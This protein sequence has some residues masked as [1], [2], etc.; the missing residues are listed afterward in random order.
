MPTL[1]PVRYCGFDVAG[2]TKFLIDCMFGK[3]SSAEIGDLVARRSRE[4]K[5][6]NAERN[7]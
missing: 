7:M 2:D 1:S 5:G 3:L 6:R 4:Q